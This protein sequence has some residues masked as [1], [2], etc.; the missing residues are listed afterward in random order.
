M[1][2]SIAL[3]YVRTE[4]AKPGLGADILEQRR[5]AVVAREPLCDP[6]NLRLR[7]SPLARGRNWIGDPILVVFDDQARRQFYS[8]DFDVI[9]SRVLQQILH[10]D[11]PG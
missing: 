2:N 8:S 7:A 1:V 9:V 4:L 10:K 3:F 11:Q 5:R 6:D